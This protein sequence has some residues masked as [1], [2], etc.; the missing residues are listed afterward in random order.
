MSTNLDNIYKI[1]S[2]NPLLNNINRKILP[3]I[4]TNKKLIKKIKIA[5]SIKK[6]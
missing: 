5:S 1:V 3:K 2:N 4:V 6:N